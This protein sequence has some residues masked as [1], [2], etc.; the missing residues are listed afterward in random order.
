MAASAAFSVNSSTP[1]GAVAVAASS[2][3]DLALLSTSGVNSVAW[4]IVGNHDSAASNPTITPAGSPSGATASFSMPSGASQAY[5]VQCVV[6][7]GVNVNGDT[8][9]ALTKR[10][11][12]GVVGPAGLVPFAVGETTERE[13]DY[14]WTEAVNTILAEAPPA[15]TFSSNTFN[16][17]SIVPVKTREGTVATTNATP[18][19][20][21]TYTVSDVTA[22][23]H[24]VAIV[25]A[26]D[27]ANNVA[28]YKR[29]ASFKAA[30]GTVTQV[31]TTTPIS[32]DEEAGIAAADCTIDN[33]GDDIR[34]RVTGIAATNISWSC[35]VQLTHDTTI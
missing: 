20:V 29:S 14:G 34:V 18:A 9:A 22:T 33:S 21:L 3:V 11:I 32:D 24:I 8:D 12:V 27:D 7:G 31:G 6:N 5:L 30:S 15:G 13:S 25:N 19:T 1:T 17:G 35:T 2:T 10:H 4:S 28:V 23:V 16:Y 26:R